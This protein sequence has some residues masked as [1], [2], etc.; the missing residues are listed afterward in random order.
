VLVVILFILGA[1]E[2]NSA[3]I[4][5]LVEAWRALC[6]PY[7]NLVRGN[8]G[9]FQVFLLLLKLSKACLWCP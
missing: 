6:F 1:L 5:V 7:R 8:Y 2:C 4:V 3:V 9:A